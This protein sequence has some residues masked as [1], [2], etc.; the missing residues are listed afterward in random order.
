MKKLLTAVKLEA[1]VKGSAAALPVLFVSR[2][3]TANSVCP[4]CGSQGV[5]P[6]E[7]GRLFVS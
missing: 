6:W 1:V 7:Y 5:H 2:I 4:L 3:V